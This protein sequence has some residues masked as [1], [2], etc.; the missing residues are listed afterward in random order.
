M[1]KDTIEYCATDVVYLEEI[2]EKTLANAE[3]L[4]L[5]MQKVIE[6][7]EQVL[8]YRELNLDKDGSKS[9]IGK[10]LTGYLR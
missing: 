1:K 8:Y 2:V 3:K 10:T 6:A 5:T 4:G 7:G 9:L